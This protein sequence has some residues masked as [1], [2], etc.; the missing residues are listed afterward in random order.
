MTHRL[1]WER[2]GADWPHRDASRFVEAGGVRWHVQVQGR[3]PALLLL[4]G[5]GASTH[6]WRDLVPLL[7]DRFTVV[8]PDLPGHAFTSTPADGEAFTLPGMARSLGALLQALD[9]APALVVGHSAG[10]AVALRMALDGLAAPQRVVSLNGALQPWDGLPAL[11]FA[12]FAKLMSATPLVPRLFAWRAQDGDAVQ[13]LV[14]GTGSTLEP[15]G[16]AWY[17]KLMRDPEHVG[18]ALAMMAHW[19]L[20]TLD[21]D[22]PRLALPLTLVVGSRDGTVPPEQS[23][24]VAARLPQS[25]LVELP[26]LGHL[27]H[28][29][30]PQRVADLLLERWDNPAR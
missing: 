25:E 26:G 28:E 18:G 14:D 15:A 30:Q 6:S 29:E 11:L 5:T 24:R 19:N 9:V 23:R 17:A 13:R 27:A 22:L 21:V 10:A 12:P 20:E 4:H 7:H 1:V 3:G 2:D 8:A 16:V